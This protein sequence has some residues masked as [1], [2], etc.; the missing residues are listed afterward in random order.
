MTTQT[1]TR[2]CG[3]ETTF[4]ATGLAPFQL[5]DKQAF[6]ER[7]KCPR[8]DPKLK[9]KNERE[10]AAY[11]AQELEEAKEAEERAGYE[12]L[13]GSPKQVA[14]ATK[15]RV[16]L[17]QSAFEALGLE[18]TE[19]DATV[20]DLAGR[21]DSASWWIEHRETAPESLP[22]ALAEALGTDAATNENPF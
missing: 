18:E 11:Q 4:D 19:F 17:I 1:A 15:I 20:G 3:C 16:Q 12:A 5:K 9:A 21:I 13:R 7:T 14:W 2:K 8:C 22:A 6:F 10:R